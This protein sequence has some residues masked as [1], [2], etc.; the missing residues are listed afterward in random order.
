MTYNFEKPKNIV[1]DNFDYA[2]QLKEYYKLYNTY[3]NIFFLTR[4]LKDYFIDI[5]NY[6]INAVFMDKTSNFFIEL[7]NYFIEHFKKYLCDNYNYVTDSKIPW[8]LLN[9]IYKF[10][11][12]INKG[13][14]II[15]IKFADFATY[16][17]HQNKDISYDYNESTNKIAM[18]IPIT[19]DNNKLLTLDT[20]LMKL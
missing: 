11:E 13:F 4:E 9:K 3:K 20:E 14:V 16:E 10:N 1:E 6:Y 17:I 7:N 8:T 15:Y 5:K 2:K 18:L 19:L 12:T